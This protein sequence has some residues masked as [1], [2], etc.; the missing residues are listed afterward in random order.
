MF[1]CMCLGTVER[2]KAPGRCL[3][4]ES[5]EPQNRIVTGVSTAGLSEQPVNVLGGKKSNI[6][7]FS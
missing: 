1:L 5:L 3:E 4:P 7:A 2:A 6:R